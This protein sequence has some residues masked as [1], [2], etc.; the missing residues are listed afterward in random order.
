MMSFQ[1][2]ELGLIGLGYPNKLILEAH[3]QSSKIVPKR[4]PEPTKTGN[5]TIY[6]VVDNN[7]LNRI[8]LLHKEIA[9]TNHILHLDPTGTMKNL[10]V[11][12]SFRQPPSIGTRNSMITSAHVNKK[13]VACGDHKCTFCKYI[14]CTDKKVTLF[15]KYDNPL[16]IN[17]ARFSC[18]TR[19]VVY[20]IFCTLTFKVYY[21]GHT[22]QSISTRFYQHCGGK[23]QQR[24]GNSKFRQGMLEDSNENKIHFRITAIQSHPSRVRRKELE[25]KWIKISHPLWNVQTEYNWWSAQSHEYADETLTHTEWVT[26]TTRSKNVCYFKNKLRVACCSVDINPTKSYEICITKTNN[27][28]SQSLGSIRSFITN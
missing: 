5:D 23:R 27:F 6:L 13:P 1:R 12:V 24:G 19:N 2:I 17:A 10:T 18:R 28:I 20:I 9:F 21:V 11:K 22:G 7:E 25:K 14:I 3:T 4:R 15:D 8:N 16:I 26:T